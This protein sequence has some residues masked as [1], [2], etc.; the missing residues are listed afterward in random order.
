MVTDKKFIQDLETED[1]S[2]RPQLMPPQNW[3]LDSEKNDFDFDEI[4]NDDKKR[5]V[6]KSFWWNIHLF[7]LTNFISFLIGCGLGVLL[8]RHGHI[9]RLLKFS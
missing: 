7:T 9:F 2:S 3:D 8:N 1:W 5:I 4:E 6:P